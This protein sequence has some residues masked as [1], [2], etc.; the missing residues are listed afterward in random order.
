MNSRENLY[1]QPDFLRQLYTNID[2]FT[3]MLILSY[4]KR[5]VIL[6][7]ALSEIASEKA[8]LRNFRLL[9]EVD[10]DDLY[11]EIVNKAGHTNGS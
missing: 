3:T 2:S 9:K 4:V 5:D 10:R 6:K 7:F 11:Q 1:E 8:N